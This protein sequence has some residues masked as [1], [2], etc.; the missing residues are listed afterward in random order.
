MPWTFDTTD[1]RRFWRVCADAG[2]DI[3]VAGRADD[4]L[5]LGDGLQRAHGLLR[6]GRPDEE[7]PSG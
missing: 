2:H 4:L 1:S 3:L 6:I 5:D 7:V